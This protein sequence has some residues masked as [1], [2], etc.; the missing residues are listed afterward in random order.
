MRKTLLQPA[1]VYVYKDDWIHSRKDG[2]EFEIARKESFLS[3]KVQKKDSEYNYT[4]LTSDRNAIPIKY[5]S[6][7]VYTATIKGNVS[8][9]LD[10]QLIVKGT[11]EGK[12]ITSQY[13]GMDV[14]KILSFPANVNNL[15]LML[16]VSGTG[17]ANIEE[18]SIS[19]YDAPLKD[20]EQSIYDLND[21]ADYLVL[22]N[23]YP[24]KNNL[25]RNMFVHRRAEL[26]QENGASVDI[27]RLNAKE[28]SLAYYKFNNTFVLSGGKEELTNVLN[29]KK[30]KK[31]L[32][33]FVDHHMIE[34]IEAS[35]AAKTP[36]LI[37]IHGV[38]TEKWYRRWFNF[39]GDA[40]ALEKT[41][42]SIKEN[43]KRTDFM[44]SV[45]ESKTLN[46]K[47]IF[48]SKWF[49]EAVAEADTN[50]FVEDYSIIHNVVDDKMFDYVPKDANQRK[51]ILSI[52]PFA[53]HKYAN[54]LSVKAILA[55]SK[56]DYFEEFEFNIYGHGVLFDTTL[57]PIKHFSN[58]H[59]HNY[60]L[61]QTEIAKLHKEHGIF[62][63]PTRLDSQGVS[64]CEA[65][66]S[67][68]IPITNGVTAIPEFVDDECGCL[69]GREDSQG[70][71]DAID[72]LYHHPEEFQKKS[73]EA[74]KR[75][76]KQCSIEKVINEEL[77]E[78]YH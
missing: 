68:L 50:A 21:E 3:L 78:I 20:I 35:Q 69:A 44:K 58:V 26:Y 74:A 23:V 33:H 60:F 62:L 17:E 71:A 46:I 47:F 11:G 48:V 16:R 55:L 7:F 59:I 41:L 72:F 67:G 29:A 77:A 30:Y 73:H 70:L 75:M 10:V 61:P 39:S 14:E 12:Q 45:Y 37:W 43:K 56:K 2:F 15:E 8:D 19:C 40:A 24:E 22:T 25:Y 4:F 6:R 34:A 66:S 28:T 27:F 13:I 9:S 51:K 38:E 31:I 49:K 18:V 5:D 52:R 65:M 54:D 1:E 32:I 36:I 57:E 42:A 53:S 63:C 64:M 76:R